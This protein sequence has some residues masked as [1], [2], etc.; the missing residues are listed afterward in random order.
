MTFLKEN[1]IPLLVVCVV[2]T[3]FGIFLY[4][5]FFIIQPGTFLSSLDGDILVATEAQGKEANW[6]PALLAENFVSLFSSG[7]SLS[8]IAPDIGKIATHPSI[9]SSVEPFWPSFETGIFIANL[10]VLYIVIRHASQ[11]EKRFIFFLLCAI[12]ITIFM[13]IL[14]RPDHS[15]IPDFDYRYAGPP[16]Y[17]YCLFIALS[18]SIA[19]KIKKEYAIGIIASVLVVILASQQAFSFHGARLAQES[20]MR[21]E[22]IVL[23][24][25]SLL[26]ELG[27]L[28]KS[29]E[30]LVIPNLTGAH[31]FQGMP[32]YTLA[33][34][35]LFFN[36]KI[37]VLLVQNV[38]MPRDVKTHIVETTKSLRASTSPEFIEA[39]KQEGTIRS[40]YTSPVWLLYSNI[41]GQRI[42]SSETSLEGN[43]NVIIQKSE[44]DPEK[45]NVVEFS[46]Y[47]DNVPGN[48]EFTFSFTSDFTIEGKAG[49][50]RIDD[51]TPYT[52]KDGKRL[53]HIE[54]NMLQ[55]YTY[56]LS[57]NISDFLLHVPKE[58]N[59]VV[60][61]VY[62]K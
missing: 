13:V 54:I 38:Y 18:I 61:G 55:I 28:E 8:A 25:N 4:V 51:Y 53:Y 42:S 21:Q 3:L 26:S 23:L 44:F 29:E 43:G 9:K 62:L 40:Y 11:G 47:T 56:A 36:K 33:D 6:K 52:I 2:A 57:Q 59:P 22:A 5:T 31:I 17:F 48:L 50:V 12:G 20:K 1:K 37:P 19:T 27:R 60:M 35:L 34:Y 46:L 30:Q 32:G 24:N 14:A 16:F 39:L 45:L 58:K 7:V 41:E 10:L 49:A 15:I